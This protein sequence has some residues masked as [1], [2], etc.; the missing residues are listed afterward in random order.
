MPSNPWTTVPLLLSSIFLTVHSAPAPAPA[1][2]IHTA[3]LPSN[4]RN[5]LNDNID[6]CLN[7]AVCSSNGHGYWITLLD[8]ISD[9]QSHPD[10]SGGRELFETGYETDIVPLGSYG[11][12]IRD[13]LTNHGINWE[14]MLL[15]A[16]TSKD[17][18]TGDLSFDS[19][20][21]NIVDPI[22]GV[23]I[24]IE[25][26]RHLDESAIQLPW[27]EIMYQT[28][29]TVAKPTASLSALRYSIQHKVD[30]PQT[31]EILNLA[32]FNMGYPATANGDAEWRRWTAERETENWFF[33]LLGTDNCKGTM[34]LLN[35][36]A[37]EA[38]GKVVR[39]IWTRWPGVYPDIWMTVG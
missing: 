12:G 5:I 30:N 32:Y 8:T 25:N 14:G 1:G 15:F 20:Y 24:A 22:Q 18:E 6:V 9:P 19:A 33:A 31:Q 28:W 26:F 21:G 3:H 39:E 34:W 11:K 10:R 37:V 7:Y 17:K 13:D 4:P 35:D 16:S 23:I 38:G 27:S 36:H 29:R 2:E